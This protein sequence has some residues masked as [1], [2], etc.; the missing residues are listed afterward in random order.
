MVEQ[1]PFEIAVKQLERAAQY[2]DISEEALE[3]LK[4]PQKIVEVTIPVEMDDG[5]VKVFTGF[6]VQY[7]WARGPTKGGIRWHPEETLSTVKA[8]A[9]WMT[10]KTAVMDLPYGGGK[11]GVICNPK[12]MSDREKE[13]LAR[14][15]IRAIYDVISPYTDVPAPD[16]YTN[17]QIM[18]WMMDEYETISR[19]KDPAFGI[20]TGKPPS[21]GGIVARM[22]A[23]ARGA[24]FA[25][26]EAAKA[27]GWDTLEGKTI[28]IQGYG[29]AGYYMAKIM[30]E[31]YGMKVVA[32]SDSRGGIY[33][34]DGL[35]ADEVLAWKKKTGSVK[36]FPG[37]TTITNEEL[38]ELDVDVLAPSAIEEVITK[39]NA[40]NIKGKIVAEL[41]NGPTTPEAD[42]ILYEKGILVIPDFLCNAGGVTVSYFEWVQNITGDYWTVEETRAK[43][44]KKMTK[45]FWDVYNTHKEKNINMR[46]AAYVVAVQRVYQAMLD[47]GWIKK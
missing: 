12:E 34:P 17:P 35:N 24:A 47:R 13:R 25:V 20:I 1:D 10:W 43:L 37:A 14:G 29:N 38:L 3:F 6:R 42:E 30:S 41:A 40:D 7:N 16:V 23:T 2:M 39:K 18:A 27:L 5:S 22:D 33:N 19:R 45:A 26:R 4:R 11:G 15:Y 44:D 36:D 46:D 21:V 28:A 8:L 31:E 9:A 32:V